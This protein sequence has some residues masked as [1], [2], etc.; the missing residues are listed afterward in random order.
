MT[1]TNELPSMAIYYFQSTA[2]KSSCNAM[3]CTTIPYMQLRL[4]SGLSDTI[5]SALP[6]SISPARWRCECVFKG[7]CHFVVFFSFSWWFSLDDCANFVQSLKHRRFN[8]FTTSPRCFRR[9]RQFFPL[10]LATT[11]QMKKILKTVAVVETLRSL[12]YSASRVVEGVQGMHLTPCHCL[13]T[14]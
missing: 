6:T 2:G 14:L 8:N 10:L 1:L 11:L 5:S 4:K 7:L 12:C 3:C 13:G 9:S